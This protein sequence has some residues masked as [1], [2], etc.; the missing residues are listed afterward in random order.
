MFFTPFIHEE[1][2]TEPT[3]KL[4]HVDV[5][6]K[7]VAVVEARVVEMV[8]EV[9]EFKSVMVTYEPKEVASVVMAAKE[10]LLVMSTE[11]EVGPTVAAELGE[12]VS[13]DVHAQNKEDNVEPEGVGLV[14]KEVMSHSVEEPLASSMP[15]V[16]DAEREAKVAPEPKVLV[17]PV[18][19]D[20]VVV[21]V[22]LAHSLSSEEVADALI[23]AKATKPIASSLDVETTSTFREESEESMALNVKGLK[24][25]I[26]IIPAQ[27]SAVDIIRDYFEYPRSE[28]LEEQHE[29]QNGL[30][31]NQEKA[32]DV[33]E[34]SLELS[35][36][37]STSK[38][39]YVDIGTQ[40][41]M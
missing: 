20:E 4:I 32:S 2:V 17:L 3:L 7:E 33:L 37:R 26:D 30:D 25:D 19:D 27:A 14:E 12:S 39:V 21:V 13:E 35:P 16:W 18:V 41:D 8:G 28:S 15:S 29:V 10:D 34:P 23:T 9:S 38:K 36:I 11:V 5:K 24:Q 1:G 6:S 31:G 40:T 22:P